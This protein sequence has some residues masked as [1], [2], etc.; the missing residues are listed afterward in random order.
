MH[1]DQAHLLLQPEL[2]GEVQGRFDHHEVGDR[3]DPERQAGRVALAPAVHGMAER[4]RRPDQGHDLDDQHRPVVESEGAVQ[5]EHRT[6]A[7]A[8]EVTELGGQ[9]AEVLGA[10]TRHHATPADAV[11][12]EPYHVATSRPSS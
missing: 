8:P 5:V 9:S 7:L 6:G 12:R 3:G 11:G 1:E 4:Q 10:R 2:V